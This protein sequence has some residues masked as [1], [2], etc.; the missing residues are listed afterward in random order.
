MRGGR[1]VV[2]RRTG[3]TAVCEGGARGQSGSSKKCIPRP[4][5]SRLDGTGRTGIV[6]SLTNC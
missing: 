2:V 1:S 4:L 3:V 5:D 6:L